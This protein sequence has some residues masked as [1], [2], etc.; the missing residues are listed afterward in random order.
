MYQ[1][2]SR[3]LT[4]F[5]WLQFSKH[6]RRVKKF[7]DTNSFQNLRDRGKH[8]LSRTFYR[9][10]PDATNVITQF[11]QS[12]NT[13]HALFP[14]ITT[15]Q[16]ASVR[17]GEWFP[18]YVL[19]LL[20]HS[21]RSFMLDFGFPSPRGAD[22]YLDSCV[23][24]SEVLPKLQVAW[25]GLRSLH[26]SAHSGMVGLGG[27][28][29]DYLD[30]INEWIQRVPQLRSFRADISL[31]GSL[32]KTLSTLPHLCSLELKGGHATTPNPNLNQLPTPC[33][34]SLTDLKVVVDEPDSPMPLLHALQESRSL[35]TVD[36]E[37]CYRLH[38]DEI[39][40]PAS[41]VIAAISK[42]R[43]LKSV[44]LTLKGWETGSSSPV[45]SGE[46]LA[47]LFPIR[48]LRCLRLLG[49]F[50][51]S[52]T[53]QDLSNAAIAWPDLALFILDDIKDRDHFPVTPAVQTTLVGVQALYNGCPNLTQVCLA[54]TDQL[55]LINSSL[56]IPQGQDRSAALEMLLLG[57]ETTSG[58]GSESGRD[59]LMALAIRLMFPRLD[60]LIA[61]SSDSNSWINQVGKNWARYAT[62]DLGEV[63]ELLA[64]HALSG[65]GQ[66]HDALGNISASDVGN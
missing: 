28:I 60:Q 2:F 16:I 12:Y 13:E 18:K 51:T 4:L 19:L 10:T 20:A 64:A 5:D 25:P 46:L 65:T 32:I 55:P 22:G 29:E 47:A 62:M 11:I 17:N 33:F 41:M 1:S 15:F 6:A 26:I 66:E 35:L 21:V 54:V 34:P 30:D 59:V 58:H 23:D 61:I 14:N 8:P 31:R 39:I 3:D 48:G 53:D 40:T 50:N 37:L 36:I 63:K 42:F 9:L 43:C 38:E 45:L 7:T 44:H 56:G 49:F 24:L 57:F 27:S 52:I